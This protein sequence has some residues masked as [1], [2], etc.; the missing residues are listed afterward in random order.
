MR[1]PGKGWRLLGTVTD[2]RDRY[3]LSDAAEA[4]EMIILRESYGRWLMWRGS[5]DGPWLVY[6]KEKP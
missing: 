5:D 2:I 6:E 4:L 3:D 1:A